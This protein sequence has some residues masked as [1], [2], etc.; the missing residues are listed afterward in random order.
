MASRNRWRRSR[1]SSS[2]EK[3]AG[4]TGWPAKLGHLQLWHHPAA[5]SKNSFRNKEIDSI[6]HFNEKVLV[7]QEKENLQILGVDRQNIKDALQ[8]ALARFYNDNRM[9][10]NANYNFAGLDP[11]SDL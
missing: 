7:N 5:S 8:I 10:L 3:S 4:T 2:A 1:R 6:E 9:N 11:K